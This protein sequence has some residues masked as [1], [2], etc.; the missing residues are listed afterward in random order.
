M[1]E[2]AKEEILDV[3]DAA[4]LCR[5]SVAMV[6]RLAESGELPARKLGLQWRL[7][8]RALIA[9]CAGESVVELGDDAETSVH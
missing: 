1:M 4:K 7:S 9:W 5:L 2:K 6:R 8:R 3:F